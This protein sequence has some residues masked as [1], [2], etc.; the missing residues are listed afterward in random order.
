MNRMEPAVHISEEAIRN[1]VK[2]LGR[3]LSVDY[4]GADEVLLIGVLRGCFIFLADLSR[5]INVPCC[6][7]FIAVSSYEDS[8][9][10]GTIELI[11]DNRIDVTG[12]HVLIIDDI[13]DSGHTLSFLLKHFG[14]RNPASLKTC[15][16]LRKLE[17]REED[18]S[19]DYLGFDIPDLWV[20][21]YGLDNAGRLRNLPYI[22]F[23][24]TDN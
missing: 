6:I 5:Q 10:P 2:E 23:V 22:G 20:F 21:G 4:A 11:M 19:I 12:K 16:L 18:V 17:R 9:T 1:R 7:D 15:V 24:K 14:V 8:T 13:V 3:M